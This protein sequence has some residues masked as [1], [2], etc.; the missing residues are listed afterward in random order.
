MPRPG[1]IPAFEPGNAEREPAVP[2]A[3]PGFRLPDGNNPGRGSCLH[4]LSPAPQADSPKV[5]IRIVANIHKPRSGG[6]WRPYPSDADHALP[7]DWAA[8][9]ANPPPLQP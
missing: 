3:R 4:W 1:P 9:P 5:P 8:P 2:V 7:N 6:A